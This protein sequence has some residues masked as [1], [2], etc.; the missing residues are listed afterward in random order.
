MRVQDF[1]IALLIFGLFVS[2]PVGYL[3]FT[4]NKMGVVID[5]E[6]NDTLV[7]MSGYASSSNMFM[8][9]LTED[10]QSKSP[11]GQDVNANTDQTYE[12][13]LVKASGR[14]LSLIPSSY[15]VF[16]NGM[17]KVAAAVDLDPLFVRLGFSVIII[18]I[19]FIFISGLFKMEV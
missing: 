15:S 1:L 14:V 16:N 8:S 9:N 6:T 10:I 11:G 7:G 18:I 3:F 12:D 5:S 2:I 17:Q 13:N 4:Y 19:S